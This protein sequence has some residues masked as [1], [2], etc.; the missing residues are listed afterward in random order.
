MLFVIQMRFQMLLDSRG[1]IPTER[2]RSPFTPKTIRLARTAP[3]M[4]LVITST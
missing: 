2:T 1:D 3:A 4:V